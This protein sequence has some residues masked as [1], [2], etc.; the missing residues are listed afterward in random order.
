M[1]VYAPIKHSERHANSGPVAPPGVSDPVCATGKYLFLS[2]KLARRYL[3][4]HRGQRGFTAQREYRCAI[5]SHWHVTS[6]GRQP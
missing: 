2:R 3:R 4:S 1:S 5:C 6:Q